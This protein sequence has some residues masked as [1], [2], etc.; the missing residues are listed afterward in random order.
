MS[1]PANSSDQYPFFFY[2]TL[3][4]SQENYVFLRGRTVY[5]QPA[6]AHGMTLFSMR[7]YPVMTTGSKAVH[8][9]LM[10]I[11]PRFYYDMLG[12]LDR[13]EGFNPHQPEDCLFRRELI[14][15]ET[16]AGAAISAW[17]YMGN[18]E[19]VK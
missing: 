5:E 6:S 8:G 15:V 12:E 10:I 14:T 16:E 3:R 1:Y 17:A 7:S 2:G 18:D 9:E 4:H 19:M 11:H 13:M